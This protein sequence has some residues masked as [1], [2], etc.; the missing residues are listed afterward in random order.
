M[1]LRFF[2]YPPRQR[3]MF[4]RAPVTGLSCQ[5]QTVFFLAAD[6]TV[7]PEYSF[8]PNPGLVST[9]TIILNDVETCGLAT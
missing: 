2:G 5:H 8:T 7:A 6:A 9:L 4:P 1:R 3:L